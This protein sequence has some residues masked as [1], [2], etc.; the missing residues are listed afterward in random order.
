MFCLFLYFSSMFLC[1]KVEGA[2]YDCCCLS[3]SQ[4]LIQTFSDVFGLKMPLFFRKLRRNQSKKRNRAIW[5]WIPS[6]DCKS[7]RSRSRQFVKPERRSPTSKNSYKSSKMPAGFDFFFSFHT[8]FRWKWR[9]KGWFVSEKLFT[10]Y[11]KIKP[12]TES[13]TRTSFFGKA[14][15]LRTVLISSASSVS[16]SISASASSLCSFAWCLRMDFARS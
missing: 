1:K 5:A 9:T 8:F 11:N 14:I 2:D 12:A 15:P 16:C 10:Q 6:R 13:Y 7:C 3:P 4:K